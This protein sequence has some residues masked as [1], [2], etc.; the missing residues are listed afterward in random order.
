MQVTTK[1]EKKTLTKEILNLNHITIFLVK[2]N[3]D[4]DN[5]KG[6]KDVCTAKNG[7]V[8]IILM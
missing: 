6:Q 8:N 5:S 1:N 4:N 7:L 3:K 2:E